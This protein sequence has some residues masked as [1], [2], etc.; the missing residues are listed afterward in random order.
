MLQHPAQHRLV[1]LA[2]GAHDHAF[3]FLD[4]AGDEHGNCGRHERHRQDHRAE[5]RQHHGERH[6][7]EHLALDPGEGKDRQVHHH[8][9]QLTEDQRPARLAGRREHLMETLG[10]AQHAPVLVLGMGQTPDGVFHDHHRAVDND[11]EVQRA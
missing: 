3:L 10:L 7:V 2:R 11:A 5:Q 6:R 4:L 9:D 8:D 1:A